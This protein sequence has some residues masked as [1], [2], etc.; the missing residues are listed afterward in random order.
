[1]AV[2]HHESGRER[3]TDAAAEL[4]VERGYAQTTLRDIAAAAGIKAGSIYYHF[5]SKE[6]LLLDILHQG[7]SVMEEAFTEAAIQTRDAAG[8]ERVHAHVLAHL[9]ALFDHG[10]YTTNHVSA[11]HIAPETVRAKVIPDRD[12][13]ERMWDDL[14]ADLQENGEIDPEVSIGMSRLAL[15]GAMN[16]AVEWFDPSRGNLEEF[17]AVIA[18]QFWKGVAA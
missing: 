13:Y 18:R 16:F 10:P 1:M 9:S 14:L 15:F 11:F 5:E 12:R 6:S 3:I 4:F 7:I 8:A 17:A 2:A